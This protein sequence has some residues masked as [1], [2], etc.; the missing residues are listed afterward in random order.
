MKT[1][2]YEMII[3]WSAEDEA[4]VV[5][6]PEL[7]GCMADGATR[8]AAIKFWIKTAKDDGANIPEPRGR[9]VF[10]L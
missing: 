7:P 5:D 9:L 6:V 1:D 3:W 4:Y 8:Q 10:A 2:T